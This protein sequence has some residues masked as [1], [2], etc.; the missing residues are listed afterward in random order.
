MEPRGINRISGSILKSS[1]AIVN[2]NGLLKSYII[3]IANSKPISITSRTFNQALT[4]IN[5]Y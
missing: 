4:S 2:I 5:K 1:E 3:Y